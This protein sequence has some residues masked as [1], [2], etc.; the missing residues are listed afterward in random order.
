MVKTWGSKRGRGNERRAIVII[1]M[2]V[3]GDHYM[4]LITCQAV[5]KGLTVYTATPSGSG[6]C[7][8]P[9][10]QMRK[11]R[12]REV[13]KLAHSHTTVSGRAEIYV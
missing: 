5:L 4:A 6:V 1:I 8:I 3:Q 11:M 2:M 7:V 10:T 9:I 13:K 12:P